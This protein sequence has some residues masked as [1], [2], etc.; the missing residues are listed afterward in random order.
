MLDH[1]AFDGDVGDNLAGDGELRLAK[2]A[3]QKFGDGDRAR[4]RDAKLDAVP[5][6]GESE[7]SP[8]VGAEV[9]GVVILRIPRRVGVC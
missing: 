7:R 3:G 1:C 4:P 5:L 8:V 6:A 2:V 9:R